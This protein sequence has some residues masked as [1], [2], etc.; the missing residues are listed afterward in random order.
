MIYSKAMKSKRRFSKQLLVA[1]AVLSSLTLAYLHF[2]LLPG[3]LKIYAIREIERL[4][5]FKVDFDK[6]LVLPFRG[7][8]FHRLRIMKKDGDLLFTAKQMS[9]DVKMIPFLREKKIIVANVY[10]DNPVYDFLLEPERS[11]PPPPPKTKI[12]GQIAVPVIPEGKKIDITSIE[13]GPNAFLPENVYLEQIEIVNGRVTIRKNSQGPPLE[14]I[15]SIGLRMGFQKPPKLAFDGSLKLGEKPYASIALKGAWNLDKAEYEFYL[16]TQSEFIPSWLVQYQKNSF[17]ILQSGGFALKTHLLS[18]TEEKAAFHSKAHLKN[19]RLLLNKSEYEGEMGMDVAGVF[20]FETKHFERYKGSLELVRVNISNL[21]KTI[22]YLENISGHIGF[23]PDLLTLDTIKGRYQKVVFDAEGSIRSFKDL[24]VSVTIRANSSIQEALALFPEEQKKMLAPYDIQGICHAVTTVAGSLRKPNELVTE[25]KLLIEKGSVKNLEK[26]MEVGDLSAE[27]FANDAGF[28]IKNSRFLFLKK[29]YLLDAFIPK[30][31]GAQGTLTLVS[32]ELRLKAVYFFNH[33]K[34]LIDRAEAAYFGIAA[35]AKG[36]LTDLNN[37]HLDIQGD[38]EIDLAESTAHFAAQVPALKNA[39][40]GG[41]LK[42]IF[43]LNGFWNDPLNWDVKMDGRGAPVFMK[44]KIRV[45]NL[46]IQARL[47]NKIL[48]IPYLHAILYG[49]TWGANLFFDLGRPGT[50]FDGKVFGNN[51]NLALL[52][53]DLELKQ[54][55]LRGQLTFQT[56]MNGFLKSQETYRGSGAA[57]IRNGYLWKTDLFKQMGSLP[58]VKVIGM[59]DIVF[60]DLSST[61]QIHDKKVWTDN[62]NLASSGV[63]LSLKGTIGFDQSL[64]LLMNIRYS[65]DIL[66]GAQDVGGF[67]PVVI[68]EAEEFISQYKIKGTLGQPKYEKVPLPMGQVIG[69]KISNFLGLAE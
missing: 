4:T 2:G 27:I 5:S 18:K 58:F 50:Y 61:F 67:V 45:D 41:R 68:Q 31:P 36:S 33:N 21:S 25:Y 11:A 47:K 19:A 6:F 42:G 60:T 28:Q 29:N 64:D 14:I 9:L 56:K 24:L 39:G 54:K 15:S 26:K 10:L 16:D 69:K 7:L 57:D 17:L 34:I 3:R 12:S 40:L 1:L 22:P 23:E 20:N 35:V 38:V 37:P 53:K 30:K 55:E 65:P 8:S 63:N 66:R 62:L 59:D 44:K 51:I 13:E 46:E 43:T 49:G 32:D 52:A 48:N